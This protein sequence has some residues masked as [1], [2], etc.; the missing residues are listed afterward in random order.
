MV[1]EDPELEMKELG[2]RIASWDY[3]Q[4]GPTPELCSLAQEVGE[5]IGLVS[6]RLYNLRTDQKTVEN[7]PAYL[8]SR[9]IMDL[10]TQGFNPATGQVDEP[11]EVAVTFGE[12]DEMPKKDHAVKSAMADRM[13]GE[14]PIEGYREEVDRI[15]RPTPEDEAQLLEDE[16]ERVIQQVTSVSAATIDMLL[17]KLELPH[18][19]QVDEPGEISGF[20]TLDGE[21]KGFHLSV[22]AGLIGPKLDA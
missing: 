17:T 7:V 11:I 6:F 22:H 5:E 19:V 1:E 20:I 21:K 4:A 3:G 8:L 12:E 15:M 13:T 10:L 16:K 2:W 18:D 9:R 14:K